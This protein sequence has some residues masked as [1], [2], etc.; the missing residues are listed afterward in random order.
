MQVFEQHEC[1]EMLVLN[2]INSMR[3]LTP[4]FFG[5][6]TM[7]RNVLKITSSLLILFVLRY[8]YCR[9]VA[10]YVSTRPY[11]FGR[12]RKMGMLFSEHS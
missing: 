6:G 9:D 7:L 8:L 10:C 11:F 3:M 1:F 4:L 5:G 2:D 12:S